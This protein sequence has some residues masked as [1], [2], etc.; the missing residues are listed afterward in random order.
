MGPYR[1]VPAMQCRHGVLSNAHRV[2]GAMQVQGRTLE[3]H[4][5]LGYC[6]T[7]RGSS[8]PRRYLWTQCSWDQENP[9]SVMISAA[10]VPLLGGSITGCIGLV[11]FGGREYR[12]ATYGG[13]KIVK[14]DAS[15]IILKQKDYLLEAEVLE[16][17][18]GKA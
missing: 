13:V 15:S 11:Y 16:K 9:C 12:L 18:E 17:T 2:E 14:W 10:H 8:F 7:D 3:F 5:G 6:E 1:F 4:G